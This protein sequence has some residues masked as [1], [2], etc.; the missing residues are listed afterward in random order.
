MTRTYT[1]Q[2]Q[3]AATRVSA[4]DRARTVR[5]KK[6]YKIL[7][8]AVT[9]EKKKL[10][11]VVSDPSDFSATQ[12][13]YLTAAQMTYRPDPPTGYMY[14]P[15]GN[16]DITEFCKEKCRERNREAH[17]VSVRSIFL[18]HAHPSNTCTGKAQEA[19]VRDSK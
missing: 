16:R 19:A 11:S 2:R 4:L 3:R 13:K 18:Y 8:E 10:R 9:Q 5:K 14:V 15:L 12:C 17:I 1:T 6:P 7:L